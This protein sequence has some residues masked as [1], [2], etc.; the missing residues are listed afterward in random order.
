M[1]KLFLASFLLVLFNSCTK[2]NETIDPT[3]QEEV[4]VSG[5]KIESKL[6][7]SHSIPEQDVFYLQEL[8]FSGSPVEIYE[9]VNPL[10]KETYTTY[11][12]EGDIEIK[13]EYL[14]DMIPEQSLTKDGSRT[15]QYRTT[16]IAD[17]NVYQIA[18][19]SPYRYD[20]FR[21]ILVDLGD[22]Q[23]SAALDA[24]I[25]NYNDLD[26]G[27]SFERVIPSTNTGGRT[28]ANVG[29]IREQ[30]LRGVDILLQNADLGGAGGVAGFPRRSWLFNPFRVVNIPHGTINIDLT[31][32]NFGADV[33]EHVITHEMGHCIGFRH[34]DFFN[35]TLSG[36]P[37]FN[38]AGVDISNEGQAGVGAIRIP[39]T[40]G[41]TGID[42]NSIMG[43]CFSAN[44]TGEFSSIDVTALRA[45]W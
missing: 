17:P 6:L 22:T 42:G 28:G 16:V 13:A 45:L 43:A 23:I 38:E 29:L 12:L 1:R 25:E 32:V 2:E 9:N 4:F 39:G 15:S 18:Y 37:R 27:I 33:V 21:R 26:L 34:T 20:R 7:E 40:P 10:S 36:C 44:E 8:G 31:T 5:N 35:R 3:N 24:A 11:L 19:N 41:R 14:K 30:S